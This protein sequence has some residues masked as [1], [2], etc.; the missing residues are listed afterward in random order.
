MT[1]G[2]RI[3][4]CL[5]GEP[6]DRVPFGVG[7]G[8]APWGEAMERWRRES[9]KPDLNLR[10]EFGFDGSFALPKVMQGPHPPFERIVLEETA[11]SIVVRN[12]RGIT[13]RQLKNS[14]NMPDWLDYPVKTDDHWEKLKC[15]RLRLNDPTRIQEDWSAFRARLRDTGEAVQ[16][17]AFPWGIFGT[18]RDFLGAEEVLLAFYDRPAVVHDMM[19]HLTTLWIELMQRVASEVRIDHIH[20]WEDMS[21]RQGSLISPDM[22]ERFMM[23]C[24]DRIAAFAASHGVRLVSVDSDGDC[25]QLVPIMMR[26]GINV[27]FPFEVQAGN[28]VRRYR[29]QY[30]TLGILG[31][32]DKLALIDGPR[33]IDGEIDKARWMIQR[34]RFVPMFDH[35]IPPEVP[36][37][38]FR[39]AVLRLKDVCYGRLGP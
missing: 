1:C 21:G 12:E 13:V 26:H 4:K 35:L 31:G 32:L 27:F 37:E 19:N 10:Q 28:D 9:G 34:G 24:Y 23:P 30:P 15:E 29:E 16:F 33:A 22:I 7:L 5:A 3:V 38:H 25:S 11:A 18:V 39:Y 6:I 2:E 17:G 20:I 36:W 14:S 8:F